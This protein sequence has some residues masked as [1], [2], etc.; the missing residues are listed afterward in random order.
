MIFKKHF[1]EY[2]SRKP[3]FTSNEAERYLSRYG[4]AEGYSKL[5]LH[6]MAKNNELLRLKKGVYT[7]SKN[8]AVSGYAFR[9]FYYG[10]E[11]A[12][13]IRKT[14]TQQSVPIVITTSKANPGIR[15]IMGYKVIVRRM[16]RKYFFG[17]DYVNYSNLFIPVSRPEK[18][19]LDFL[20]YG[21]GLDPETLHSLVV[22]SDTHILKDY[23]SVFGKSYW[24]RVKQLL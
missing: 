17:F 3:V 14:W 10:M 8:E 24:N 19:I 6:N 9:P 5:L 4:A 23:A 15:R 20:Y 22:Q 7:F 1:S 2:F 18:I 13:T 12:L 16:N 21:I 11:Y